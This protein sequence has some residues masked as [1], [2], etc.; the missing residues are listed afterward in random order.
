MHRWVSWV[1]GWV[2][3]HIPENIL[4]S[5][6]GENRKWNH[7]FLYSVNEVKANSQQ[8]LTLH[9][10]VSLPGH[11]LLVL[12]QR[13]II[14]KKQEAPADLHN[15][16][17]RNQSANGGEWTQHLHLYSVLLLLFFLLIVHLMLDVLSTW[18]CKILKANPLWFFIEWMNMLVVS[19]LV[20]Y[21]S[22]LPKSF[23][24]IIITSQWE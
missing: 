12:F 15:P 24:I 23:I 6:I 2:A 11:C 16:E 3:A 4:R 7:W 14:R 21:Y 10:Y 13:W 19:S 18:N 9:C 8:Q 5:S 22:D 1:G 17:L 20:K